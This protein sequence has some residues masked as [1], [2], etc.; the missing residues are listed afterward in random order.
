MMPVPVYGLR[1]CSPERRFCLPV[2]KHLNN[3]GCCPHPPHLYKYPHSVAQPYSPSC[4]GFIHLSV[5]LLSIRL[6]LPALG[7]ARSVVTPT[8]C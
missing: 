4:S 5:L 6:S 3:V 8:A 1:L 7:F 2:V